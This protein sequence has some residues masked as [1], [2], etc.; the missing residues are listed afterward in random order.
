MTVAYFTDYL[1]HLADRVPLDHAQNLTLLGAILRFTPAEHGG[2][3]YVLAA[4]VVGGALVYAAHTFIR[5]GEE[6]MALTALAVAALVCAPWSPPF[7]WAWMLPGVIIA[8]EFA[9]RRRDSAALLVPLLYLALTTVFVPHSQ[10][11]NLDRIVDRERVPADWIM[12]SVVW[13]A[14]LAAAVWVLT[15]THE[16]QRA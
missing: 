2:S 6:P 8:L 14:L 5:N 16:R 11:K 12:S 1:F 7:A 15:R 9:I 13:W 10:F 4:A 3:L